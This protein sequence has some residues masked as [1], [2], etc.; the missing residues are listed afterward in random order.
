[1][2]SCINN[3]EL[4]RKKNKSKQIIDLFGDNI[5]AIYIQTTLYVGND[6]HHFGTFLLI[7]ELGWGRYS[8]PN[9]A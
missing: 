5:C 3:N 4:K 2:L 7:F 8:A 1:M 6:I 9:Q